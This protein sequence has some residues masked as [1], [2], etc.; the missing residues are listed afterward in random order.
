MHGM[1]ARPRLCSTT[2]RNS[3]RPTGVYHDAHRPRPLW[4]AYESLRE[5][6]AESF[7]TALY[8]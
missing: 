1:T 3:P 4:R 2:H 8:C 6:I 7:L 5:M